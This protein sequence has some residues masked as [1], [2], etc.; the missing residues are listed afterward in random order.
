MLNQADDRSLFTLLLKEG[1]E[2]LYL[3]Y[4]VTSVLFANRIPIAL[5][6]S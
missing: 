4:N 5:A 2:V 6:L 3:T 1:W